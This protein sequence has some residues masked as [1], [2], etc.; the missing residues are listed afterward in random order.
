MFEATTH[1]VRVEVRPVYVE[2]QSDPRAAHYLF[3]YHVKITNAG[4]RPLRLMRRRWLITDA[5]G[6]TEEV[7]GAGVVGRQPRLAPGASFEYSSFC[8]LPTPHGQM[9]GTYAMETDSGEN[10][11]V[12]IPCF[13]LTEP[14]LVH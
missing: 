3:S 13:T 1:D 6:A 9:T 12:A 5:F 4:A 7:E 11:E 8:P 2:A 10:L 14:G